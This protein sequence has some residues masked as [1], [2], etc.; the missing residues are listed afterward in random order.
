MSL[1]DL[2]ADILDIETVAVLE[3]ELNDSDKAG[4][5]PQA[6]AQPKERRQIVWTG[7]S[8]EAAPSASPKK[9]A[10]TRAKA[11]A[12]EERPLQRLKP[13]AAFLLNLV[14]DAERGNK[15]MRA[16]EATNVSLSIL[17]QVLMILRHATVVSVPCKLCCSRS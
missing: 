8:K 14:A 11:A 3:L 1:Y 9:A 4:V 12:P 13:N 17:G 6:D 15:R 7:R 16:E 5:A 2:A 10:A